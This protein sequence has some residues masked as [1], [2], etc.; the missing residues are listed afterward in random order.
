VV[1]ETCNKRPDHIAVVETEVAAVKDFSIGSWDKV[2]SWFHESTERLAF[3][4]FILRQ[5]S[6]LSLT[7][8]RNMIPLSRYFL[9]FI[10]GRN[11]A[12]LTSSI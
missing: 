8:D 9:F 5:R 11:E 10:P 2:I 1:P 7:L 6:E 12:S 4:Q 3:L